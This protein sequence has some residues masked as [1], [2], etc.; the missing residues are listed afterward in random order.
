MSERN[1]HR[2]RMTRCDDFKQSCLSLDI[3][4]QSFNL[5]LPDGKSNYRTFSGVLMTLLTCVIVLVFATRKLDILVNLQ[6]YKV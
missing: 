3:Y 5:I 1:G 2:Y 6:D 4:S